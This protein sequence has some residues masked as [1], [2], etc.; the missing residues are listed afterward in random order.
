MEKR[1]VFPDLPFDDDL[2]DLVLSTVCCGGKSGR[3]GKQHSSSRSLQEIADVDDEDKF[4]LSG[5]PAGM[6]TAKR[7]T[8][9]ESLTLT[10]GDGELWENQVQATMSR[11]TE[12]FNEVIAAEKSSLLGKRR[13]MGDIAAHK[14]SKRQK[15]VEEDAR[16]QRLTSSFEDSDDSS[17][18]SAISARLAKTEGECR[19]LAIK[20]KKLKQQDRRLLAAYSRLEDST[21]KLRKQIEQMSTRCQELLAESECRDEQYRCL[22]ERCSALEERNKQLKND[23]KV[24]QEQ[25]A[26]VAA[27]TKPLEQEG[28][29]WPGA[30][31]GLPAARAG[32]V[33]NGLSSSDAGNLLLASPPSA[34]PK[35]HKRSL[36]GLPLIPEKPTFDVHSASR[37]QHGGSNRTVAVYTLQSRLTR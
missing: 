12:S 26:A 11:I 20:Y 3:R 35:S 5:A 4:N 7:R 10:E 27:H 25:M 37:Q 21:E 1:P 2:T 15:T 36:A 19:T 24:L 16:S 28:A 17:T 18:F 29:H 30:G 6:F 8:K 23:G 31:I 13:K 14:D 9:M 32:E 33:K 34:R 22:S